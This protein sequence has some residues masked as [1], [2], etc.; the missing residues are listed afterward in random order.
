MSQALRD[1][2]WTAGK[3]VRPPPVL[4]LSEWVQENVRLPSEGNAI[5]GRYRP[6]KYQRLILD[7]IGD[8]LIEKVT[9]V[10]A[11]RTGFTRMLVA[12]IG[13]DAAHDP[14]PII[15]LMPTDDDARGIVV[16]EIDPTFSESPTLAGLMPSGK[17]DSRNRLTQRR[18]AGGGS[19]K[20]LAA[21]SPRNLR[22][23][24]ARKL[25]C[26]EVDGFEITK[27][28]DPIKLGTKR[29]ESYPDRKIIL[30]ST[31][32]EDG[33]SLIQKSYMESDQRIFEVPCPHCGVPFELLWDHIEWPAG[34]PLE[35]F[36]RCPSCEDPIEERYKTQMVE[37]GD[38]RIMNPDVKDHAGVRINA[39][40]SLQPQATWGKLAKEYIEAKRAGP[41][42]LQV[43]YN[44]VLAL[45][46]STTLDSVDA[47]TLQGRSEKEWGIRWVEEASE[48]DAR[49]PEAVV[50]I[51]AGVDVQPD[52]L[53]IAFWG[54]SE[55]QRW[56]LGH[57]IIRG[58]TNLETTWA[59]LDAM[60]S[61]V[62]RHPLGGEIGI[63][64]AAIDSGDGNRTQQVY[65][66]CGPRTPRKI[67]P[68]KG[69]EGAI[70]VI[71]SMKSRRSRRSGATAYIVGVD[72]VKTD[73]LTS[74]SIPK[75]DMGALRF[76]SVLPVEWFEQ[77]TSERRVA[78]PVNGRM[79]VSFQRIGYRAAEALD[80]S[81]Y[82]I[83][84]RSLCRFNYEARR[85]ELTRGPPP[86]ETSGLKAKVKRLHGL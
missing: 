16:D 35:A 7:L 46:W 4:K 73:I 60:L 36:A 59:E 81:V 5:S 76:S 17:F 6:W 86:P 78:K 3:A 68:I 70:P 65:D 33:I 24:T 84:V 26:D 12:A 53:E 19:L 43:F 61:T 10:K 69:R 62:W 48:W 9:M 83:A 27:E 42:G 45:P 55:D 23:H 15:L 77:F 56:A 34:R 85:A 37:D 82:A 2:L 11:T 32:T 44:T 57:E 29:T 14:C 71:K 50:Y 58:A 51:T 40:V 80:G 49:L 54:W 22:R 67:I 38:L 31:P 66:F 20:I 41:A 47:E 25:Y 1:A 75:G 30:G 64:A 21:R 74:L 13:A 39:L 72:Q 8:P 52:R 79:K 63:E 18:M 28:G